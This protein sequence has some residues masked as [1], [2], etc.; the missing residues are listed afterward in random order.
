MTNL[1]KRAQR[2]LEAV[3]E[4]VDLVTEIDQVR[5]ENNQ[6]KVLLGL[7]IIG[8]CQIRSELIQLNMP[9]VYLFRATGPC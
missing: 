6:L 2:S 7:A 4:K 9:F 1:K 8:D 3:N 5:N